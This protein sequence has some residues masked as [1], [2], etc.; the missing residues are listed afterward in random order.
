M[1]NEARVNSGLAIN[2]GNLTYS[3][4]PTTF[5]ADVSGT[6]GPSPGAL[7]VD[8]TGEDVSFAELAQPGLCRLMNLEAS[9]GSYV[10]WGIHDGSLFHPVGE[11]G[12]GESYVIRLSRNL[13]EE[14][15]EPGTGTTGVVNAFYLR[16]VSGTCVVLVEA[17]EA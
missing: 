12:P 3:A 9:G 8:A 15:T 11:I 7:T 4:L 14:H 16:A 17:F 10:E 5:L 13:G 2:K 6:K 1:A